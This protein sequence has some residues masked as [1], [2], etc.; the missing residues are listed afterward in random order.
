[1]GHAL[2]IPD[3]PGIHKV[4]HHDGNQFKNFLHCILENREPFVTAEDAY[5]NAE[6][7]CAIKE[8]AETGKTIYL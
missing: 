3:D 7:I 2:F 1:M 4:T 6:A 8:S 5:K